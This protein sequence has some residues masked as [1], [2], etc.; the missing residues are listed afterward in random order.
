LQIE[1]F[2]SKLCGGRHILDLSD[3]G[4]TDFGSGGV[5]ARTPAPALLGDHDAVDDELPAPDSDGLFPRECA[6]QARLPNGTFGAQALRQFDTRRLQCEPEIRVVLLTSQFARP[7]RSCVSTAVVTDGNG[8][9]GFVPLL[10]C[11]FVPLERACS[12]KEAAYIGKIP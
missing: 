8:L 3:A 2:D 12:P 7:D 4:H 9:H 5:L 6:A 1:V 11:A 10:K